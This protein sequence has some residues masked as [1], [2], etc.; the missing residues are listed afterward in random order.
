VKFLLCED[1]RPEADGK[2][3]IIGLYADDRMIVNVTPGVAPPPPAGVPIYGVPQLAIA[4]IVL[5]GVGTYPAGTEILDPTGGSMGKV[6]MGDAVLSAGKTATLAIKSGPFP[7]A[8]FGSYKFV[9]T[10][11]PATFSFDFEIL[12]GPGSG[13]VTVQT[14]PPQTIKKAKKKSKVKRTRNAT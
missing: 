10:L 5:D 2:L 12:A 8:R 7:V 1:V 14:P 4:S 11:G 13:L 9:L 6:A 3:T